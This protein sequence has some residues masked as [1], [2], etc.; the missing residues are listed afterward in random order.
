MRISSIHGIHITKPMETFVRLKK[1]LEKKNPLC[2][3][4]ISNV[5][6]HV[7]LVRKQI[8]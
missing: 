2:D 1:K 5:I 6:I 7:H 4:N 3:K 8:K